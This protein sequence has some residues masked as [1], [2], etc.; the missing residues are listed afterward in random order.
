MRK[1]DINQALNELIDRR[2]IE[3]SRSG[4]PAMGKIHQGPGSDLRVD[5]SGTR[6]LTGLNILAESLIKSL[7]EMSV[8]GKCD[9]LA[10]QRVDPDLQ[11][12][13]HA[14]GV[15]NVFFFAR[16]TVV[17]SLPQFNEI[18]GYQI[19]YMLNAIQNDEIYEELFPADGRPGRGILF[20]FHR[21][22]HSDE[23]GFFYLVEYVSA[24][25][26]L[27]ITLES[28]QDSRLRLSR[29]PH[30]TIH[31]I[32][33]VHARVD[34][35][36]TASLIAQGIMEACL[37][38]KCAYS[39][40]GAHL[41]NFI[42]FLQKAGMAALEILSI[43]WSAALLKL[44]PSMG[45]DA[46]GSHIIRILY[47]LGDSNL[48]AQLLD[49][50]TIRLEDDGVSS[51]VDLSQHD[52]C[53]NLALLEPR[54]KS[55][56]PECLAR[57]PA[58]IKTSE[59]NPDVFRNVRVLLIHH[60]T[61]EVLGFIQALTDMGA[62]SVDTLWVKYAGAVEPAYKEIMLSLP[63][64]IFRFH[65]LSPLLEDNGMQFRYMLSDEF[66]TSDSLEPLAVLL[67][68][69]PFRFFEAMRAVAGYLLFN[70]ALACRRDGERFM[71]VEDGGYLAPFVN[72]FC[73]ENKTVEDFAGF[74][75]F[76]A[77][78][79]P[80]EDLGRPLE[81]WLRPVFVGSV[82][83]TR[84]GYD[85][86]RKVQSDFGKLAFPATTIAISR[87]KVNCESR[88]VVYS[89]LNAVENIMNHRGFALSERTVLV[90]GAQGAIGSK[91]MG[92]LADRVGA[93]NLFG[94]DVV[95]PGSAPRWTYAPDLASLPLRAL[96]QADLI[97]GVIGASIC[98]PEWIEQLVLTTQK[99]HLFFASG[100]TKNVEFSHLTD[101]L[102]DSL[103]NPHRLSSGDI[104]EVAVSEIHDPKTGVHQGR[105]VHLR[106]GS[107]T[108]HL[109][110]LA[111]L[112]PVNF[113]YYGVPSETMNQVMNELLG[114]SAHL[115]RGRTD[116]VS[117]PDALLALDHEIRQ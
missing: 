88:D 63:E 9:V 20:P 91:A 87:F 32:D 1:T 35:P 52:R 16:L 57:M 99:Q 18:M 114:M 98:R 78:R 31:H 102:L 61:S 58:V 7:I 103:Q 64:N 110:L 108:V 24:G 34:I 83:H 112:M 92:I 15:R 94:V 45:L 50:R 81:E 116:P 43:S 89:C 41:D 44:G 47:V 105:S 65:G 19:R 4:Q 82:E 51:F 49:G 36:G 101:W 76:P 113:L 62:L 95:E 53:L 37:S 71:V 14:A 74:F 100:S 80:R 55:G 40:S 26:F 68:E 70:T 86:L 60:L 73:L 59:A 93:E 90:L 117:L 21:E 25:H 23:T 33:L 46:L 6:V 28:T 54:V 67:E 2:R 13:L 97:F 42:E 69:G 29:I 12:E 75:G 3:Q 5:I 66:S 109:H 115:V 39:A 85:A 72:R 84:N 106:T 79:L 17:E 22:D 27:R 111:D 11:P 10:E 8:F 77:A 56:L 48:I 38:Q 107:K 30:K 104:L 96:Q